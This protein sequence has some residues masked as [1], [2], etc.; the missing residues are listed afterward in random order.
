MTVDEFLPSVPWLKTVALTVDLRVQS[1][2]IVKTYL[3]N[4]SHQCFR[5]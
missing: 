5:L 4:T 3:L 2:D 1:S